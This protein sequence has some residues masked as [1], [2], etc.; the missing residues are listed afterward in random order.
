MDIILKQHSKLDIIYKDDK[1]FVIA[2]EFGKYLE[3]TNIRV[4]IS[5]FSNVEKFCGEKINGCSGNQKI[6][7]LS[8]QGIKRL[9]CS[10]RK[11]KS[12]HLASL[13]GITTN[14]KYVPIETSF[15]INIK[16]TFHGEEIEC[17]YKVDKYNIDIYFPKYKL[18]IEI[19]EYA[20]KFQNE[21]DNIRQIY[22]ENKLQCKFIRIKEKD[23]VF[24]SI[25]RI[26]K[27]II[28]KQV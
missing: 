24:D 28:F 27:E 11:P 14:H 22:I 6:T 23:D 1:F 21:N 15:V 13:C 4:L 17:Q 12:V 9:L 8:E 10:S 20:H 7:L 26:F 2:N 3:I 16:K 25:N 19:D 5:Q 18:A